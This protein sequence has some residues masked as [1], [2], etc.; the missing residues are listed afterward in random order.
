MIAKHA[1]LI[2]REFAQRHTLK[3]L[4]IC[5]AVFDLLSCCCSYVIFGPFR[6]ACCAPP[7]HWVKLS[8]QDLQSIADGWRADHDNAC[9]TPRRLKREKQLSAGSSLNDP[10]GSPFQII[11]KGDDTTVVSFGPDKLRGT[12]DDIQFPPRTPRCWSEQ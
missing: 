11:C 2:R 3:D 9:P 10:W 12:L 4:L 5:L 8:E 7:Q 1:P 6:S